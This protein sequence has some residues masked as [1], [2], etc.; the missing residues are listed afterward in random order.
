[1]SGKAVIS[2]LSI[3]GYS[4]LAIPTQSAAYMWLRGVAAWVWQGCHTLLLIHLRRPMWMSASTDADV[5]ADRCGCLRR[6]M[7]MSAPTDANVCADRCGCLRRPMRTMQGGLLALA[8][9][10]AERSTSFYHIISF[11]I[12]Q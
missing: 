3:G 1:M 4:I 8:S 10:K 2:A 5:C 12:S 9:G 11:T 7:Q 6:P